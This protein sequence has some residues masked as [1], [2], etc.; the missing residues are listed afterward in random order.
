MSDYYKQF[1]RIF[2][3]ITSSG[4]PENVMDNL[5]DAVNN[6]QWELENGD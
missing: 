1:E 6:I 4:L 5:I 3:E 2:E